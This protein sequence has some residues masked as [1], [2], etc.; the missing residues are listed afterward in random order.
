MAASKSYLLSATIVKEK[1]LNGGVGLG[2]A[3]NK[4]IVLKR[5]RL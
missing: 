3:G 1:K 4:G 5:K 2:T